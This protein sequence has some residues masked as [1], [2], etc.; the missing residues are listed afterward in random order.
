MSRLSR[1][2]EIKGV[3]ECLVIPL[4]FSYQCVDPGGTDGVVATLAEL[5]K[6]TGCFLAE[7]QIQERLSHS[8][9]TDS[10]AY[11]MRLVMIN[12]ALEHSVTSK[13]GIISS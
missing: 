8:I 10:H 7:L 5:A 3:C 4:A 6:G 2:T 9:L 11:P 1:E 13:N 12:A